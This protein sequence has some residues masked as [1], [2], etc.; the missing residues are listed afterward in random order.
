MGVHARTRAHTHPLGYE[1]AIKKNK[2]S[3][4]ETTGMD[5]EGIVLSEIN[6]A[7]KRQMPHDFT[8]MWNLKNTINEQAEQKQTHR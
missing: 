1:S 2:I 6:Q 8:Y 3:P 7:E 4:S 5:L